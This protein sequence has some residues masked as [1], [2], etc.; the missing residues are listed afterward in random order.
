MH[1]LLQS[2]RFKKNVWYVHVEFTLIFRDPLDKTTEHTV[3]VGGCKILQ[4][5]VTI[6]NSGII[7]GCLPST[8][9]G[10]RTHPQHGKTIVTQDVCQDCTAGRYGDQSGQSSLDDCL[11]P[12]KNETQEM[13]FS[14]DFMLFT[15]W[16][17]NPFAVVWA[18]WK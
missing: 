15:L 11:R 12:D 14:W 18:I 6:G 5:L 3:A 13:G 1:R 17:F 16:L 2:A 4:Q 8:G 7:M 9:A 10:F